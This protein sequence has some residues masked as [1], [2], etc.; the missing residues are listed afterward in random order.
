MFQTTIIVIQRIIQ[1]VQIIRR[2]VRARLSSGATVSVP[3]TEAAGV[4]GAMIEAEWC[5]V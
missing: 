1:R 2:Q 3:H 4:A 5:L